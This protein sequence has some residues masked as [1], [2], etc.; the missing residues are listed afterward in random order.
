MQNEKDNIEKLFAEKFGNFE[1]QTSEK[2]WN[3]L[4]AKLRIANFMKFSVATFNIYFLVTL[5]A[6]AG[7]TA[8]F[9]INN[10]ILSGKVKH[11]ENSIQKSSLQNAENR[12][13]DFLVDTVNIPSGLTNRE[14]ANNSVKNIHQNSSDANEANVSFDTKSTSA[15]KINPGKSISKKLI[16]PSPLTNSATLK[17]RNDIA[18][19]STNDRTDENCL[20]TEN[21]NLLPDS[22]VTA[23]S[24]TL[25]TIATDSKK[26]KKVKKTVLIKQ[27]KVVVKDTIIIKKTLKK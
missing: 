14:E 23:N 3:S 24:D 17:E 10:A 4:Y 5:V 20:G 21:K 12:T 16:N 18:K 1:S 8:F 9:G 22:S 25:K 7:T 13:S 15:D 26:I 2:D 11:L 19:K 6:L 27:D